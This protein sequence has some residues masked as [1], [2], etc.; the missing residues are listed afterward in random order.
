MLVQSRQHW[1]LMIVE[2]AD[3]LLKNANKSPEEFRMFVYDSINVATVK[4]QR[5]RMARCIIKF[6]DAKAG[7]GNLNKWHVGDLQFESVQQ[8]QNEY[9][10]GLHVLQ[11]LQLFI[12]TLN[13]GV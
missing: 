10:C 12:R 8:Q 9:D 5:Q 6:L 1:Y 13:E 7:K 4:P 11:N 2:N 3:A